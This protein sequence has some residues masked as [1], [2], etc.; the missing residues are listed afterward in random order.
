VRTFRIAAAFFLASTA[1]LAQFEGVAE[2]RGTVQ[3]G[4]GQTIPSQGKIFVSR[5]ACRV[6]WETDLREIAEGRKESSKAAIP[7]RM[8]LVI[9][10]KLAEPDRAY[11]VNEAARTYAIQDSSKEKTDKETPE[12]KWK[13]ERLGKDT[14]AG[15]SCEKALLTSESGDQTEVCV[16]RELI[17]SGAWLAAMNRRDEQ[18]GPLLALKKNGLEGFPIRWIFRDKKKEVSSTMELVRF[19]KKSLPSSLFEIPAGYRETSLMGIFMTSEQDKA[20]SDAMR[21]AMENMTPEQ[22]K[23]LEEMMKK[24]GVDKQ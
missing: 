3:T 15:L 16:S 2:F 9:L 18:S 22:R 19:D 6:E 14:V 8:R 11:L 7:E 13:V 12:K 5:S 20:Y 21:K 24:Q 23:Q 1:A 17:P 4:K 10:Q